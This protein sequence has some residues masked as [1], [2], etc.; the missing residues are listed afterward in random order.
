MTPFDLIIED[1]FVSH[2]WKKKRCPSCERVFFTKSDASTCLSHECVNN[3][4]F[5]SFSK[6]KK[7]VTIDDLWSSTLS[8]FENEG[9]IIANRNSIV[10]RKGGTLFVI[11][12]MQYFDDVVYNENG[13]PEGNYFIPQPCIRLKFL[14]MVGKEE[15]ISTSFVNIC[16]GQVDVPVDFLVNHIDIW[17]NYLSSIGLYVSD[18]TIILENEIC[19]DDGKFEGQAVLFNYGGLEIGEGIYLSNISQQTRNNITMIDFGFGLERILW[20]LNKTKSYYMLVGPMI[21]IARG[22]YVLIDLVRT[23]T[24]IA[25]SGIHPSNTAHGYRFRKLVK[26]IEEHYLNTNLYTLIRDSYCYWSKFIRPVV[27]F[28][29]CVG[30]IENEIERNNNLFIARAVQVGGSNHS[31]KL[32]TQSFCEMLMQ[33]GVRISEIHNALLRMINN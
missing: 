10:N 26:M 17:L 1:Y 14:D 24:L 15:G 16:T 11:A 23:L 20:A 28:L 25:A 31:S 4:S 5:L 21:E 6:R 7:Q 8:Y 33:Q 32:D 9:L 19:W 27:P 22:N 12:G 30:V 2:R 13:K 18:M 29:G 3:Y